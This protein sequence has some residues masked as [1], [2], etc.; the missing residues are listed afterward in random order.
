VQRVKARLF[1]RP[2]MGVPGR[3][4]NSA[5]I[6]A[7]RMRFYPI[8]PSPYQNYLLRARIAVRRNPQ[9]INAAGLPLC[10]PMQSVQPA[11]L[12]LLVKSPYQLATEIKRLR[13]D[14]GRVRQIVLQRHLRIEWIGIS[15]MKDKRSN[16]LHSLSIVRH[17]RHRT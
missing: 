7:D 4:G 15:M 14:N 9:H 1:R 6:F 8:V 13:P 17:K 2:G 11:L 16:V 12:I 10:I 3:S 5:N